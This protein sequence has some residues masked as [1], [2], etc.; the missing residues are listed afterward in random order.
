MD[1]Y[2]NEL[3]QLC[4]NSLPAEHTEKLVGA[5]HHQLTVNRGDV[6]KAL[7]AV[8]A[9]LDRLFPGSIYIKTAAAILG[10][11]KGILQV[12]LPEGKVAMIA[13][14]EHQAGKLA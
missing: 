13:V 8:I 4:L 12:F 2:Q 6:F 7:D 9:E 10:S 11:L 3:K 14:D 5:L 1:R